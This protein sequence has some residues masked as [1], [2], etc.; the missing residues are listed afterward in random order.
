[1]SYTKLT[2]FAVKDTMADANPLKVVRGK[3]FD[4]EFDAIATAMATQ[5]S[6]IG[7]L[8]AV[9]TGSITMYGGVGAPTG[10]L[11]CDGTLRSRDTYSALFSIIGTAFGAGDGY[12]TFGLPNLVNR[13]PFG[14]TLGQAGGY[15][16]SSLP[17]H[18]HTAAV[19]VT[20]PGHNHALTPNST[21]VELNS[22]ATAGNN[23]GFTGG[24]GLVLAID[25]KASLTG[26]GV[27]ATIAETGTTVA[28]GNIPP[29]LGVSFIIKA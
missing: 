13:F 18:T 10:F 1:M 11:P 15:A 29:Y 6:D 20:D 26:V 24:Q 28:N 25:T 9:P 23:G 27:T 22:A 21:V 3:E 16:D 4:D 8:V 5:E 17:R 7:N 19:V 2:S 12:S 14:G